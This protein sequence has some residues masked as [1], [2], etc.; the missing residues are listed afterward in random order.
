MAD[1]LSRFPDDFASNSEK[2]SPVFGSMVAEA[3][4]NQWYN[5]QLSLRRNWIEKMR[6]YAKGEQKTD[7][8]SMIEGKRKDKSLDTKTHKIDYSEL[9]RVMPVFKD[10]ITNSIDESLFKPRAEA[11]DITAVN[12][13]KQFFKRLDEDFYTQDFAK[14]ISDGIG[15]DIAPIDVPK[16]ERELGIKKLEYK[17]RIEIA[18]ELA[19]ENVLKYEKFEV[20]KDKIDEDLFDLGFC[21]ARH[22]TDKT[23][24]I[25]IKYVD[26]Y[27]YIH[28]SFEMDDGRDIRY[29][30]VTEKATIGELIKQS[31]GLSEAELLAIKNYAL[32]KPNNTDKFDYNEDSERM[33]EYISF[34]YLVP[35]SRIFKKRN[36][37]K[38]V[39]LVD[40]T[41]DG[42]ESG[43]ANKK[44]E[45][46]YLVWYEGIY[47][48]SAKVLLKWQKIPN[49]IEKG[50]NSPISPFLVYAPKVKRISEKGHIRFDSLVQRS[51]PIVDDLQRDWFKFQQLKMELRPN[52]VTISP[53]ALNSVKLNGQKIAP[54]DVLDMFFGRGIL[55][56][57]E[58]DEDGEPIGR[59]IREENGGVNNSALGFL[60]NEFSNNY[61]RLRQLLGI[62]ELRDGTTR[63]NSKT[64][65]TVQKLLLASSNNATNHLVKGSFSISLRVAESVSLRLYD[66]LTTK[67]LKERYLNIIGT[68]NV[69]LLDAI[70]ELP[71]HK[72][73]IYFDFKPDNEERIAFEQSLVNSYGSREINVAQY[74][75][76][77]QI[78]NVK[79][80]IK[81]LE[82][83]IK[84]NL[85]RLEGD[86]LK[87]IQ[88]QAQANAQTSVITEQTKQQTLTV[89][90]E[91]DKNLMLLESQLKDQSKRRDALT[92]D[93]LEERKHKRKLE[94]IDRQN[95]GALAKKKEEIDGRKELVNLNSTNQSKQ[96][97]QRKNNTGAIDFTNSDRNSFE[98]EIDKIF[99][100]DGVILD[101]EQLPPNEQ[102]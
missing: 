38:H 8:K 68:N 101:E 83:V 62:N 55:L 53:R 36:K 22:Y 102:A 27:N 33:I 67:V 70:K 91:S 40:R 37:H 6:R 93:I 41:K 84:E 30:G 60:S 82:F 66:V 35:E 90:H 20:I 45:I 32:G 18:Q 10:I 58:F 65:V 7:Y 88:A 44:L 94:I 15:I 75:K 46:P 71:A 24:G 50:V 14:I 74:N 57:D 13:K 72:F 86:K 2:S 78:R 54:K 4:E 73:G 99:Q 85:E 12:E 89:K 11:I 17:P 25:K 81:Y 59:A 1:L 43:K 29:H 42:F 51:I 92:Q 97:E 56:A 49:Q 52:T 98:N 23:E 77:R 87:N 39:K 80:A 31:D 100:A 63:P 64:S 69:Q 47:V 96:I 9:L 16:S 28:S 5:G 34:A 19:I 79:S 76:A 21:I 95:E 61:E 26:P 48:P 3:M